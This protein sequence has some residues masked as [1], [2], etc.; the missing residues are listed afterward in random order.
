M[1]S[2]AMQI[3]KKREWG[4]WPT[5]WEFSQKVRWAKDL[6]SGGW[7]VETIAAIFEVPVLVV[8]EWL[9]S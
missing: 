9:D 3:G 5:D 7:P 2:M 1:A 4:A 6:H 8:R